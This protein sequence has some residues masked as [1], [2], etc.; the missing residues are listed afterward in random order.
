[1]RG[2][3]AYAR[4]IPSDPLHTRPHTSDW[5]IRKCVAPP[6][7]KIPGVE[8]RFGSII[9]GSSDSHRA[10]PDWIVGKRYKVELQNPS[11]ARLAIRCNRPA[12]S[13]VDPTVLIF[14]R[15]RMGSNP[16]VIANIVKQ[17]RS[18]KRALARAPLSDAVKTANEA[19]KRFGKDLTQAHEIWDRLGDPCLSSKEEPT[20]G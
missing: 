4:G 18:R 16:R 1:M 5:P 2:R 3:H 9:R 6:P 20:I 19:T 11:S 14:S 10:P 15:G 13:A 12:D 8:D 7:W 17:K